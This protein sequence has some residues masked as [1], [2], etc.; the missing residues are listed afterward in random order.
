MVF[1]EWIL[2][3]WLQVLFGLICAGVALFYKRI[4]AWRATAKE[5]EAEKLKNSIV[6]DLAVKMEEC[7]RRSDEND[8]ALR[9]ELKEVRAGVLAMQGD[10]FR[11]KCRALLKDDHVITL[12][13]YENISEDHAAYNG[14]GG[15]SIGD[16]LFNLVKVKF[17]NQQTHE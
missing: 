4:K 10:L 15:N 6:K 2:K 13:Q 1:L 5:V 12:E 3:Y 16:E 7:S 17:E 9:D 11:N 8:K 14:L